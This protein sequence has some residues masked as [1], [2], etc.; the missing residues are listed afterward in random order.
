MNRVRIVAGLQ[1]KKQFQYIVL[2][3]ISNKWLRLPQ[4]LA[5]LTVP[6]FSFMP[7]TNLKYITAI[8]NCVN[9]Q[10]YKAWC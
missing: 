8:A 6:A 7:T 4:N 1:D 5:N 9:T 3:H 10:V 2:F